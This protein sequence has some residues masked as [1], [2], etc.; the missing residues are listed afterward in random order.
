VRI[1][2]A[3]LRAP[4]ALLRAAITVG[5]LAL[6]A[7]LGLF[8]SKQHRFDGTL[9]LVAFVALL[10]ASLWLRWGTGE[11]SL[12]GVM[13]AGGLLNFY[14]LPTGTESRVP[15]S[16]LIA[17]VIV[18]RWVLTLVL[19]KNRAVPA[20]PITKP[21]LAF[22]IVSIVSFGWST[23]LRDSDVWVPRSW[24]VIQSA[25]L[26]VNILLPLLAMFIAV[27][28]RDVCWLRRFAWILIGLGTITILADVL[29][30]PLGSFYASG[31]GGLF[32]SW[33]AVLAYAMALFDRELSLGKRALLFALAGAWLYYA[34][35][36]GISWMSGWLPMIVAVGI[37]TL[38]RSRKLF[39]VM[40]V[41]VV[42]IV[43]LNTGYYYQKVIGDSTA[44]GDLQRLTLWQMNLD[45][46]AKHPVFGVG[47]AGYAV[48]NMAYHPQDARSTHNNYFDVLAQTGAVGL[49]VF[50]WLFGRFLRYGWQ[51]RRA[52]RRT[53]GFEEALACATFG[54]CFAALMGMMLGDWVLPFAYNQT[55]RGFDNAVF[56]WIML[57][58]M[59]SLGEMV[60]Q[61]A[62]V[63][64]ADSRNGSRP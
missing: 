55:I 11:I 59:I 36:P 40:L 49:L 18:L 25:A 14:A 44:E 50:L 37:V 27:T 47:P 1:D 5:V 39:V 64:A 42:L 35:G 45:L 15:F 6:A 23:V 9:I 19:D 13:V 43:G 2:I 60:K 38:L 53:Y 57:G 8:V 16:L 31:A 41:S 33:V 22:A 24:P 56:T 29:H 21:V 34:I 51:A 58:A 52:L 4:N 10:V 48:Y 32:R 20:S 28:V 3:A 30:L 26:M 62:T 54:G 61:R 12:A 7:A 17:G 46:V 63:R